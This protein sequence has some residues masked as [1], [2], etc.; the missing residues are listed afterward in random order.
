MSASSAPSPPAPS[1]DR[2]TPSNPTIGT[3]APTAY[4][5][6]L[7]GRQECGGRYVGPELA[8]CLNTRYTYGAP[9]N[10]F[11]RQH[12]HLQAGN[13]PWHIY[14]Q[15]YREAWLPIMRRL[16]FWTVS[17]WVGG[18]P[19]RSL[20]RLT[21]GGWEEPDV[22][23]PQ[24]RNLIRGAEMTRAWDCRG[25]VV[26][27][28]L[29]RSGRQAIR[30][31]LGEH[32]IRPVFVILRIESWQERWRTYGGVWLRHNSEQMAVTNAILLSN[33]S[34]SGEDEPL[35]FTTEHGAGG[36]VTPVSEDTFLVRSYGRERDMDRL[37]WHIL[38]E[39]A[40]LVA[41]F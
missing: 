15:H 6:I 26:S 9:A 28:E 18:R 20:G 34:R 17:N 39:V 25:V 22:G 32:G 35:A 12:A 23:T 5:V 24:G 1:T 8:R 40:R 27:S 7:T 19:P 29:M 33:S 16:G 14:N 36:H 11:A 37:L 38:E 30:E 2:A 31:A 41:E 10:E 13:S 3:A 4:V 21:L